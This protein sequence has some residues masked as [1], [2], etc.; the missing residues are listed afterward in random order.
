MAVHWPL[1]D[2]SPKI[3]AYVT[4]VVRACTAPTGSLVSLILFGSAA[5]GGYTAA[6]SDVDLFLVMA[7]DAD[8]GEWRRIRDSVSALEVRHGVAP[9]SGGRSTMLGSFTDRITANVRSF[10]IC[11]R[12][13]LLSGEPARI[14]GIGRGQALFVDRIAVPSIVA[15]AVTVWGEDLLPRVP[16]APIR[17]FDVAKAF[18]GLFGQALFSTALYPLLPTATKYAMDAVKR[19]VHSCYYCYTARSAPLADEVAFLQ[20][21][22]GPSHL[23]T[24]LL[25]LRREY[26]PSFKFVVS[27]LPTL[28]LLHA[29]TAR[30]LS[31]PR[32][33]S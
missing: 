20:R 16:L 21:Q 33:G 25:V 23:L 6:I 17:R 28:V 7:D 31:F 15:S 27:C 8:A 10:F 14:L 4:D 5:T 9:S 12:A 24:H 2:V 29:R 30:E 11:S 26:K 18:V 22:H 19:S 13:D 3:E 32:P 1:H